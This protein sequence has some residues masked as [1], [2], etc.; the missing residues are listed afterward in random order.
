MAAC[1][2]LFGRA[3]LTGGYPKVGARIRRVFGPADQSNS[4]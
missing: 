3:A 2:E 4:I 1:P